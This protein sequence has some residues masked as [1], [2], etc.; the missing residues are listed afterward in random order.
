MFGGGVAP[1]ALD[2]VGAERPWD[3]A[4]GSSPDQP[5]TFAGKRTA[6]DG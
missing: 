2:P 1:L 6:T 5:T 4:P 3:L